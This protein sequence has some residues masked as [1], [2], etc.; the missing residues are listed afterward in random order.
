MHRRYKNINNYKVKYY[1]KIENSKVYATLI[2]KGKSYFNYIVLLFRK[3]F[4]E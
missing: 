1:F 3:I 4:S 2:L